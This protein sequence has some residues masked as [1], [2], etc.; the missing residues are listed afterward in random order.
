MFL[1]PNNIG[2]SPD[3][4]YGYNVDIGQGWGG[5][6]SLLA[7]DV[8]GDGSA[9]VLG[10][11]PDGQMRYYPNNSGSNPGGLPFTGGLVVGVG[12]QGL[13]IASSS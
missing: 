7:A 11:D 9:D 10:V 5:F 2:V 4:P 6:V 1:F 12:W 8:S 3:R 13:T